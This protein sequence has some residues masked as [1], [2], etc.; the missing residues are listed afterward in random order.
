M[1]T[2]QDL[3]AMVIIYRVLNEFK[4]EAK[5][6]MVEIMNRKNAGSTF[7]YE[8]KIKEGVEK[9]KMQL[10]IPDF[11]SIKREFISSAIS[12]VVSDLFKTEGGEEDDLAED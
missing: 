7:D 2:D 3:V 11:M 4:E 8:G 10:N 9:H 1:Q 12:G 5:A 6:S